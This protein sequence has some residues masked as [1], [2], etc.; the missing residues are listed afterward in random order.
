MPRLLLLMGMS[1]SLISTAGAGI[2]RWVDEQGKVHFGDAP[3]AGQ[4]PESLEAA[5]APDPGDVERSRE[6]LD[7]LLKKQQRS[8][9]KRARQAETR[10]QEKDA[11][12]RAS[13]MRTQR[14]LAAQTALTNLQWPGA[15]FAVDEKGNRRLLGNKTRMEEIE[16]VTKQIEQYCD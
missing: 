12:E 4:E 7:R 14:C 13:E 16:R 10:R 3:P 15:V 1:L 9:A 6:A 11:T 2:Y 8:A 5:P